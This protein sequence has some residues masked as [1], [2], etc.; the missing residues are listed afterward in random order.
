MLPLPG[1]GLT[2]AGRHA[3][4]ASLVTEL[5]RPEAVVFDLDGT[6][7]DNIP[8]HAAA[9]AR[10]GERR[11][12]RVFDRETGSR[13]MGR[14]NSDVFREL[15]GRPLEPGELGELER[16]KEALYREMSRGRLSPLPGLVELLDLLDASGI[17]AAIATSAPA[18]NVVHTLRE[19]GLPD[20]FPCVVRS[21]EVPRG[22]PHPDV[23]LAAARA[24][25]VEPERCLAFEDAPSGIA[26]ARAAGMRCVAVATTLPR[27]ELSDCDPPPQLVVADYRELLAGALGS[28]L[29]A[30]PVGQGRGVRG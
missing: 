29:A 12:L 22:K 20:R 6:L 19:I 5:A 28:A 13:L 18:P 10:F 21:D 25:G 24:V 26:A 4:T 14:R 1:A 3:Y 11:G 23:F 8:F 9:F 16:E 15:L 27:R 7:V 2:P 17:P 30:G